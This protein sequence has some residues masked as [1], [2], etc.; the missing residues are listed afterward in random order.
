MNYKFLFALILFYKISFSQTKKWDTYDLDSIVSIDLPFTVYEIDTINDNRKIYQIYSGNDSLEFIAQKLYLGKVYSNVEIPPLPHDHN[1][2]EKYYSNITWLFTESSKYDLA[3]TKQ[4]NKFN[5]KG[6]K[7]TFNNK[8]DIAVN[9]VC[10]FII[11][12]NFYSFS[13]TNT[14]GLNEFE[15][16]N[17]FDSIIFNSESELI[18]YHEKPFSIGKKALIFLLLFLL[19]S[20]LL[21]LKSKKK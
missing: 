18:Q 3:H 1:S 7:L 9:E 19:L 11:N 4:M 16:E 15:R 10:F 12:K 5:L 13:Y 14:N 8:N 6:Y 21:R 2:L 17:F 20:F